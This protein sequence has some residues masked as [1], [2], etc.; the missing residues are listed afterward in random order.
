MENLGD[1]LKR[2]DVTRPISP[3]GNAPFKG[4]DEDGEGSIYELPSTACDSCAGRGWF[5]PD[6]PAGH[7][8][9]GTILTCECQRDRLSEERSARLFRYSNLGQLTRFTFDNLDPNGLSD[10]PEDQLVFSEAYK[11]AVAYAENPE[12]WLI[13]TG[14]NG[15][16]KTHL[17]AAVANRCIERDLVVF[18]VH[19]P[20]L[21][22]HLRGAYAPGSD[23]SYS[24][25]LEQV[26]SAP[27]LVLDGLGSQSSTPWAEEKLQQI[28]NH[29][30]NAESPTIVTT[31]NDMA[32]LDPYIR[33]R[34]Q[35][36]GLSR[37][38]EVATHQPTQVHRLGRIDPEMLKRM[39]FET[40]DVRGNNP[41][42]GQRASID[43]ALQAAKNFAQDPDGWI[44]L[45]G[46]TGVG[47][48][49][50]AVAIAERRI[51][52]GK[53]V[54]FAF[55][56]ELLDYLRY[57][58]TPDS[59]VTYDRIF[60][61][62]KNTPLLI[63]DDLGQEHSSPWAYEKLYQLIVHRHNSRL[64]TVITSMKDFTEERGPIG[65]RVQDP[66][67]GSL[68]RLDAPDFRI[69]ERTARGG[70]GKAASR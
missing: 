2:L 14:P 42:A 45:F 26:L 19:V 65:S 39:T 32:E 70:R 29:R 1:I 38:V 37:V 58:F 62:I 10:E 52:H 59:R 54:F 47:K 6:V 35:A 27:I 21:L 41:T 66:S 13:F 9:F 50:L 57:T 46:E 30:Y 8:D 43:A 15:A 11:H 61:E 60:D 51:R 28:I 69:K 23:V 3:P 4:S 25:L 20:D 22:D 5:T 7:P 53:P 63:L 68:I 17:A 64:P 12:G 34:F 56:P 49:H 44:T 55:V 18:F 48:T 67:V 33:S 24:D 40:F 36:S 31:A 16:G